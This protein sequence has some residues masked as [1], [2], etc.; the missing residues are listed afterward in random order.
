MEIPDDYDEI[1]LVTVLRTLKKSQEDTANILKIGKDRIVRIEFWLKNEQYESVEGLF[2]KHLLQRVVDE[3][4][5]EKEKIIPL[6]IAHAARL[7]GEE[8]LE[9]YGKRP[10]RKPDGPGN[11]KLLEVHQSDLIRFA[12]EQL[13]ELDPHLWAFALRALGGL[14]EHSAL[15]RKRSIN[16]NYSLSWRIDKKKTVFLK[17]LPELAPENE[18]SYIYNYFIQH[19]RTSSY[20]WLI[21]DKEE[22]FVKL[23][24]LG[25]EELKHRVRLLRQLDRKV[26][27]LTGKPLSDPMQMNYAG[28]ST[29]FSESIWSGVL[30]GLYRSLDYKVEAI[31]GGLFQAK[32]GGNFIGLA[33]TK[34]EC[35]RYIE[36]HKDLMVKSEKSKTV[37]AITQLVKDRESVTENIR[38]VLTKLVV[39]KHVPGKCNYAF[40]GG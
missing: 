21:E 18:A 25:G 15:V 7:T 37:K 12:N 13:T 26:Q 20:S 33:E 39:D 23:E 35:E 29:W 16:N 8:I 22:G 31:D 30:D 40:C 28:P 38:D 34:E 10:P 17:Y 32:Y 11:L 1:R 2:L 27:K 19:L 9:H 4:L 3:K 14:G 36:W 5:T 24:L 6:E